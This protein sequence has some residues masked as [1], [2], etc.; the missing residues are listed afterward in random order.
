MHPVSRKVAAFLV[1]DY[2][3]YLETDPRNVVIYEALKRIHL[4]RKAT[5]EKAVKEGETEGEEQTL[6]G[7]VDE[8]SEGDPHP[9][10]QHS[11]N[12]L[13]PSPSSE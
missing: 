10:S 6:K 7:G 5:T 12:S 1:E 2:A 9:A 11:L 8:A 4:D 13:S 3:R